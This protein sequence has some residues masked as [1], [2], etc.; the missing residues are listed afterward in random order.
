MTRL[1]FRGAGPAYGDRGPQQERSGPCGASLWVN[2]RREP[3]K[4]RHQ[5]WHEHDS[6]FSVHGEDRRLQFEGGQC[7]H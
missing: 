6:K 7:D 2:E 5:T 1:P 3:L 4:A